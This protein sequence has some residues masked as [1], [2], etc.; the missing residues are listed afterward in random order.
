MPSGIV[1]TD[2]ADFRAVPTI[3]DGIYV[4]GTF[5]SIV[6]EIQP[7]A[8]QLFAKIRNGQPLGNL[9][10]QLADTPPSPANIRVGVYDKRSQGAAIP[11]EQTYTD[12]GFDTSVG[13]RDASLLAS[14]VKGSVILYANG[15]E[16]MAK[17]VQ[18][19]YP[20]LEIVAAPHGLLTDIDVAVV[21]TSK[22]TPPPP[23][24]G[25]PVCG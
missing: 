4:N 17:V 15:Q 5:L 20:N 19:Y 8:D 16:A 2:A 9:G 18:D 23:A 25:P 1:G 13:I 11:V 14:P 3:P 6:R 7:A 12:G 10:L 21:I 24:T 22:F